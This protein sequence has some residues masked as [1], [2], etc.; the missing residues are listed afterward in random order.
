MN[1]VACAK[2]TDPGVRLFVLECGWIHGVTAE[3]FG[4][5][6]GEI[7]SEMFT[8]VFLVVHPSGQVKFLTRR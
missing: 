3:E 7:P 5:E 4:F 2:E 1:A 6:A 8:P